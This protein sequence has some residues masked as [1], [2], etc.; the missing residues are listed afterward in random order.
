MAF[1]LGRAFQKIKLDQN[2]QQG[3]TSL[4]S[5]SVCPDPRLAFNMP[6]LPPYLKAKLGK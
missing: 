1:S 5:L 2:P 3:E 6:E 4:L